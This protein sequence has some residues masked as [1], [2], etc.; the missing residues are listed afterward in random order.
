MTYIN[1]SKQLSEHTCGQVK[2]TIGESQLCQAALAQGPQAV[3]LGSK[4]PAT[5]TIRQGGG[6]VQGCIV[7]SLS[8]RIECCGLCLVQDLRTRMPARAYQA[9]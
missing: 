5:D 8:A 3:M 2:A 6:H 4:E 7:L 1:E 9:Y